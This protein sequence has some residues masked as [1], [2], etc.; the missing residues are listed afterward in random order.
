MNQPNKISRKVKIIILVLFEM[1]AISIGIVEYL[2]RYGRS[3][4]PEKPDNYHPLLAIFIFL[5]LCYVI[6]PWFLER[7][8]KYFAAHAK[9][10]SRLFTS[11]GWRLAL[12]YVLLY[13][14]AI[15]GQTLLEMGLLFSQF[16]FFL[17]T[18]IVMALVWGIND[19]HKSQTPDL[20]Q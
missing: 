7:F 17:G 16:T 3:G 8:L 4:A 9:R 6:L 15:F 14:P 20:V 11:E 1:Y 13:S 19:L 18:T 12:S 10:E 2:L 5:S